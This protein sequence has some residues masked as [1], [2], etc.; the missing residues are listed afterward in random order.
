MSRRESCP[1]TSSFSRLSFQ[2][3]N[4]CSQCLSSTSRLWYKC[5]VDIPNYFRFLLHKLKFVQK[6]MRT[7]FFYIIFLKRC[8]VCFISQAIYVQL[9]TNCTRLC[10]FL[11]INFLFLSLISFI[12]CPFLI[13]CGK[14]LFLNFLCDEL[15]NI[16][17]M[18]GKSKFSQ[19]LSSLLHF[20]YSIKRNSAVYRTFIFNSSPEEIN[21]LH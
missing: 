7:W 18:I 8:K 1:Q 17:E 3:Q 14:F 4:Y 10:V 20:P 15:C 5:L 9:Y 19:I 16:L 6:I 21:L 13:F 11:A 2:S 12:S